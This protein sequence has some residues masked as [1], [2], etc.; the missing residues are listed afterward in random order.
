MDPVKNFA[1][2]T[3]STGY[4]QA[5]VS[6]VLSAGHGA[7]FP[8]PAA[9]GAFNLVW[10]NSTD[11]ADPSDDPNVEVVRCTA[12]STDTLTITRGQEGTAPQTHNTAG[13]TYKV[14]LA[15]T[16]RS[17]D[18]IRT[19]LLLVDVRDKGAVL[20]GTT[21][22]TA[23]FQNAIDA[24]GTMGGKVIFQQG[25]ARIASNLTVN[26]Y[27]TISGGVIP[28]VNAPADIPDLSGIRLNS[29]ATITLKEG[30]G[31]ENCLLYRYGMTF[32][33]A[34]DSLFAGT[35]ITGDG[36]GTFVKDSMII[37]FNKLFYSTGWRRINL[38]NIRGDGHNGIEIANLDDI[39]HLE[40]I[41]LWPWATVGV[42]DNERSGTAYYIHD[43]V[44]G[45]WTML[46]KCFAH[47]YKY[48]F[49]LDDLIVATLIGC[50][51]EAPDLIA[52]SI[53]YQITGAASKIS[54]LNCKAG[55]F[56]FAGAFITSSGAHIEFENFIAWLNTTFGIAHGGASS[57]SILGG[58]INGS[59]HGIYI[60]HATARMLIDDVRFDTIGTRPITFN[61]ANP[62]V[63]I[64]KNDYG[65]FTGLPIGGDSIPTIASGAT[66]T[67]P[68]WGDEFIITGTADITSITASWPK[69]KVTLIFSGTAATNGLVDGSNLKIGGTFAYSPDDAIDL[70]CDGTNWY[71]RGR[72]AN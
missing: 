9:D 44:T 46:L 7:R 21:D 68:N 65:N 10:W 4:D 67:L 57:L 51:C 32:P 16:K 47:G 49:I 13:K 31:I 12:R 64:G 54:L 18:L 27:V 17:H 71:Q 38:K 11:Y 72:S 62:N 60:D 6:I 8:D 43:T 42:G 3:V 28:D 52:G 69:R 33:A 20:D 2:A 37:G 15:F 59:A 50:G 61:V 34:D 35:A 55:A 29:A 39:C 48:G 24:I 19:S 40:N 41:H 22:D 36:S 23:A 30:A 53:G 63:I 58:F 14:A 45:D 66:I 5:A 1:K 25:K 26:K 70:I 56:D